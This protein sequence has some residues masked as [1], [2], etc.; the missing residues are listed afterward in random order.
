[1][2]DARV[3]STN[4]K[5]K[6]RIAVTLIAVAVLAV[7]AV[8]VAMWWVAPAPQIFDT[9][10]T[11]EQAMSAAAEQDRVVMAVVTADY[12]L[13]CQV[14]K[15]N[16]LSDPGVAEWVNANA[17]TVYVKWGEPGAERVGAQSFPATAILRRG[18]VVAVHHGVMSADELLDFLR[19]GAAADPG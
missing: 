6:R 13:Q 2:S 5:N 11:L 18:D 16:A 7:V 8:A 4:G 19:T 15:R 10:V 17:E 9:E 12:C 1:M 14:Y 3:E